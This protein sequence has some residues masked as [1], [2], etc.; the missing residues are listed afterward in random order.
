M[1]NHGDWIEIGNYTHNCNPMMRRA[2][3]AVGHLEELGEEHLYALNGKPCSEVG[4]ILRE[5]IEWWAAQPGDVMSD[6]EPTNGWGDS[7]SAFDFWRRVADAC[8]AY[9]AGHLAMGG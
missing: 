5:A 1:C 3:D 6:L 8:V 7:R 2:L 4:P 9:P